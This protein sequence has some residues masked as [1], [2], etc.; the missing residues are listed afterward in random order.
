MRILKSLLVLLV[1]VAVVG[2]L[3]LWRLPAEFAWRQVQDRF[4]PLV[5]TGVHGTIWEGRADGVSLSGS[6]LGELEWRLEPLPLL[7]ARAVGDVR[8]R[9]A[10]VEAAGEIIRGAGTIALRD[11]RFSVPAA[12]LTPPQDAALHQLEGTITGVIEEASLRGNLLQSAR[13]TARWSNPGSSAFPDEPMPDL[14]AEFAAEPDGSL[15]GTVRDEGEGPV[16]VDGRFGITL[17][18]FSA[19]VR[20]RARDGD[21]DV[22]ERL[23]RIGTPQGDGSTR[24]VVH[25][26]WFGRR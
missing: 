21:P 14:V 6:D 23:Q 17:A 20:L 9:G 25:V 1:L 11:F 4:S 10:E 8:L 26:P 5:L 15:A 22:T 3:V 16:A 2:A 24:L 19:D 7:G 12:R 18:A 13:G